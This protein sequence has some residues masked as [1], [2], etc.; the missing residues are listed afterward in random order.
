LHFFDA[1]LWIIFVKVDREEGKTRV[2]ELSIRKIFATYQPENEVDFRYKDSTEGDRGKDE[3]TEKPVNLM[4]VNIVACNTIV[5]ELTDGRLLHGRPSHS[6]PANCV[7]LLWDLEAPLPSRG[8]VS[9]SSISAI[10]AVLP[11][12]PPSADIVE[13]SAAADLLILEPW[14]WSTLSSDIDASSASSISGAHR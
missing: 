14:I 8:V 11:F 13:T 9:L 10:C 3:R 4:K 2:S 12:N 7:A 5:G 6:V 1:T